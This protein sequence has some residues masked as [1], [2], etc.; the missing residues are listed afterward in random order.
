MKQDDRII[1]IESSL[2]HLEQTMESLNQTVIEQERTI[3]NLQ[4]QITGLSSAAEFDQMEK[5]KST[6]KKPPHYQ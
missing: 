2:A 1:S 6:I 5:I 3:Q 4:N